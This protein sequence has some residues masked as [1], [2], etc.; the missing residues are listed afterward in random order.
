MFYVYFAKSLR[1]GKVYVGFTSKNPV[2]R[3]NEHNSG[4]NQ[5]SKNNRPFKL[6]YYE[7]L[8]CEDDARQRE[9]FYKS[10]VGKKIKNLIVEGMGT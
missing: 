3:V 7:S 6:I 10:G 5:W 8:I 9:R 1:N 2:D 4:C